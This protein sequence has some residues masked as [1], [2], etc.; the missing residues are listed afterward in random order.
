MKELTINEISMVSGGYN[1]G[2][3]TRGSIGA[4]LGSGYDD[5]STD[6]SGYSSGHSYNYN[7]GGANRGRLSRWKSCLDG[8]GLTREYAAKAMGDFWNPIEAAK[9]IVRGT[10]TMRGCKQRMNSNR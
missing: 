9:H 8:Q 1:Y 2:N 3:V 5:H 10:W 6:Y 7:F 4:S